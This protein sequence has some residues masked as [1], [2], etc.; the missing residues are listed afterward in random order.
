MSF[1]LY[2]LNK[3]V[4]PNKSKRV[5]LEWIPLVEALHSFDNV[6]IGH[7]LAH[8]YHLLYEMT[9]DQPFKTNVNGA[10]WMVK[11]SLQWY[12]PEFRAVNLEFPEGVASARILA[13]A[14]TTNHFTLSCLYFFRICRTRTDL[15]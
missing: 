8:L 13:E 4:F 7:F 12:F 3:H 11:L 5:K 9:R 2:W 1:L 15:E 14:L 6:A 10:T